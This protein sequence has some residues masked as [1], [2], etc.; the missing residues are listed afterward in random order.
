MNTGI[1]ETKDNL[2]VYPGQEAGN[3]DQN[4]PWPFNPHEHI[5]EIEAFSS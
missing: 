4:G 3:P 5:V 2:I 1:V